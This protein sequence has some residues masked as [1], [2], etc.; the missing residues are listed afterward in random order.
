MDCVGGMGMPF[1]SFA[2]SYPMMGITPVENLFIQS[3]L[4]QAP[5]DYVRVYL[6]GLMQCYY[7]VPDMTLEKMAL[8][9]GLEAEAVRAAFT[10]WE[11]RGLVE[12]IQDR[13]PVYRYIH[14]VSSMMNGSDRLDEQIYRYQDLNARLQQLI[15]D[16]PFSASDSDIVCQWIED[17]GMPEEVVLIFVRHCIDLYMNRERGRRPENLKNFRLKNYDK[18]AMKWVSEGVVTVEKA[19][20]RVERDRAYYKLAQKV[21][22]QL[23]IQFR[24]PTRDELTVARRW[25]EEYHLDEEAVLA[26]CRETIKSRNPNFAYLDS[27]LQHTRDAAGRAQM[28]RQ[29]EE[30]Q[31]LYDGVKQLH[32]ALG[33]AQATPATAEIDRYQTYLAGGFSPESVLLVARELGARGQYGMDQLDK[34]LTGFAARGQFSL[35]EVQAYLKR[36]GELRAQA[37]AFLEKCGVDRKPS[38]ADVA[39]LEG[40]LK[41]APFEVIE[42]AAECAHGMQ[43]PTKYMDKLLGQWAKEEIRT[44][45]LARSRHPIHRPTPA[46]RPAAVDARDYDQRKYV[47]NQLGYLFEDDEEEGK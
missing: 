25:L 34:A 16:R 41:H 45:E 23:G 1:C 39:Q 19:Q 27:I 7:P 8:A 18:E 47:N 28:Q 11:R 31:A 21:L 29:L 42:Y 33:I 30:R 35:D 46:Q 37:A 3:Y 15:P 14:P 24:P 4:P 20:E 26:A 10:Y 17:L 12:R 5:G 44:V 22:E 36:Q 2:D 40:W 32:Q 43:L 38:N 9:L 13:P 6:Y